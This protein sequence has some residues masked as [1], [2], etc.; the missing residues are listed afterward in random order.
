LFQKLDLG[1]NSRLRNVQRSC[2]T[3]ET[4]FFCYRYKITKVTEFHGRTYSAPFPVDRPPLELRRQ[5]ERENKIRLCFKDHWTQRK[6]SRIRL[7]PVLQKARSE[8]TACCGG[9]T[10]FPGKPLYAQEN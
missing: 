6:R 2:C 8:T 1:A 5:H 4:E 9:F 10:V 3:G 7:R